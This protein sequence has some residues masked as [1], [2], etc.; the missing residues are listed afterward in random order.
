MLAAPRMHHPGRYKCHI[1]V[2]RGPTHLIKT[3]HNSSVSWNVRWQYEYLLSFFTNLCDHN[4]NFAYLVKGLNCQL[5][6]KNHTI[7]RSSGVNIVDRHRVF[8]SIFGSESSIECSLATAMQ[9]LPNRLGKFAKNAKMLQNSYL[10]FTGVGQQK[11][12]FLWG[13]S[14]K[15]PILFLEAKKITK[16]FC[17]HRFFTLPSA[18]TRASSN[19]YQTG[20]LKSKSVSQQNTT[21]TAQCCSLLLGLIEMKILRILPSYR[22]KLRTTN[23]MLD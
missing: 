20:R 12:L 3:M 17:C 19:C 15:A 1:N 6:L 18:M 11:L 21:L 2:W 23:P 5:I 13:T 4:K 10:C 9:K 8:G 14:F 16:K 7:F 22:S